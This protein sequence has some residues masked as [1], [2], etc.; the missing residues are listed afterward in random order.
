MSEFPLLTEDLTMRSDP[1]GAPSPTRGG[2]V[3]RALAAAL[4][5]ALFALPVLAQQP[6]P[7]PDEEA[8]R[9]EIAAAG[10][11]EAHPGEHLVTVMR[12]TD[13][14]VEPSGLSHV[15]E[16]T[17][18]K[19]LDERGAARLSRLRLDYDPASNTIALE[20]ARILRRDGS[21][22][23]L[24]PDAVVDLPQP[25]RAIYWGPRMKLLQVPRLAPGDAL[26]TRTYRKGFQIAYL[27][28]VGNATP[29]GAEADD[30][31]YVPPMR[32][33]FYDVVTFEEPHPVALRYYEVRLPR[34][35]PLQYEV[36]N[37]AVRSY[38]TFDDE[39]LTYSFW[40]RDLG[41]FR[42]EP[43]SVA[44]SDVTPKVVMATVED[45][46]AKSRWFAEVN[47]DQFQANDAIR[48]QVRELTADAETDREKIAAITHW[49]ANNIRYSG[50]SMGE[51]EGYTLHPG[52]MV[53]R[54]RAGVCKD[55]AGMAITMLRAA[56]FD[57]WP[58]MTMA[59]SR[60]ER[61][62]ADQFNH[63]VTAIRQDDGEFLMVD[64]TW[65]PFSRELWSSAEGEQEYLV[66]TPEGE[67]LAEMPTFD[68]QD[69]RLTVV[70]E[71]ELRPDGSLAGTLTVT[72]HG[73]SDQRIRRQ[74]LHSLGSADR[75][76]WFEHMIA[77]LGPG[78]RVEPV[79][80]STERILDLTEPLSLEIR[81]ELPRFA[82]VGDGALF[83]HPPT[84]RHLITSGALAPY[85]GLDAPAERKHPILIWA[86]R[87][88]IAQETLKLPDGY[89]VAHLPEDRTIEGEAASL[90]TRTEI[91]EGRLIY[92]YSLAIR[93]REIPVEHQETL[94]RVVREAKTLHGDLVVLERR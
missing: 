49:V 94:H 27:D 41:P 93:E 86:P 57:V 83:F 54:N 30:E 18:V 35:K 5:S 23:E 48:Q 36:Y 72:G 1:C 80:A 12:W 43:M 4:V 50:V 44:F 69:H 22:E 15:R 24:S 47:V 38:V 73:Y 29:G 68:P 90:K 3:L 11:A 2:A 67:P 8:L 62:P 89:R 55:K 81:Y 65:V 61:I 59:G 31:R 20:G 37:G 78:A 45:W 6:S 88:R 42:H 39:T 71:A 17:V 25:Q 77:Q 79:D 56:G 13:V 70:S 9:Q 74:L 33:H 19:C 60:V 52:P 16:R 53:W 92:E 40:K 21:V 14:E 46:Q 64:P 10:D 26:E 82:V 91:S 58:A 75:Q 66:G 76:V 87:M 7:P 63:C 84:A 34:D 85:L 32:G 51:G 28:D